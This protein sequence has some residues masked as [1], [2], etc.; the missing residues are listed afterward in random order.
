M[1]NAPP[2]YCEVA[3]YPICRYENGRFVGTRLLETAWEDVPALLEWLD[4]PPNNLWPYPC[5]GWA[6][7]APVIRAE[8]RAKQGARPT[9]AGSTF[10]RYETAQIELTYDTGKMMCIMSGGIP[11][12]VH[13]EIKTTSEKVYA[14]RVEGLVWAY[15]ERPISPYE[16]GIDIERGI[17]VYDITLFRLAT[18][19]SSLAL[20]LD[21]VN[22]SIYYTATLGITFAPGTMLCVGGSAERNSDGTLVRN[23]KQATYRFLVRSV[24]WNYL[25]RLE[26]ASF[27]PVKLATGQA[28]IPYPP[29]TFSWQSLAS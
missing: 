3:P 15:D 23:L 27:E 14:Q 24:D 29:I 16:V 10:A 4:T 7:S 8:V 21:R 2:R 20:L 6:S 13:E 11:W 28:Y 19:P 1:S 9:V 25:Y 26:H 5:A 17:V 22:E 12:F 18:T